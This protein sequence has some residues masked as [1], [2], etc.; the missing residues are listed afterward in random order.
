VTNLPTATS[1]VTLDPASTSPIPNELAPSATLLAAPSAAAGIDRVNIF[2]VALED[3]GKSGDKIGCGDSIVAVERQ[4]APTQA[5]LRAALDELLTLHD[6]YLGESGLYNALYQSTL[7]IGDI[8]IDEIGK[9]AI[10]LSGTLLSGGTCDAPRITA[11]VTYT[12]RQFS[13]VKEVEIYIN[14]T[15]LQEL[16]SGE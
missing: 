11:Q 8:T 4:I 2:L 10:Y 7:I 6:Q 3:N 9:A 5:P 12:A 13:T 15:L 1:L 14:G 16:L